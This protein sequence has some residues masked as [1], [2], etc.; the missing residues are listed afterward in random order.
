MAETVSSKIEDRNAPTHLHVTYTNNLGC[1]FY[2][3]GINHRGQEVRF[4]VLHRCRRS[5]KG[6][7]HFSGLFKIVRDNSN[8]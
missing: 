2:L 8:H 1:N 5:S 3:I 4:L 6:Q 7:P